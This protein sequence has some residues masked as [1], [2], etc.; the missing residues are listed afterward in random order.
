LVLTTSHVVGQQNEVYLTY[1]DQPAVRGR[2]VF[3]DT[4]ND[5][6]L[7]EIQ[8]LD[9]SLTPLP[10]GDS[11]NVNEGEDVILL[12]YPSGSF[13]ETRVRLARN[14]P[15]ELAIA[16]PAH[17]GNSGGPVLRA[18]DH[19]VVGLIGSTRELGSSKDNPKHWA[20]PISMVKKICRRQ[21]RPID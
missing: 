9:P 5:V 10:L 16:A 15:E 6:A 21:Q 14:T 1:R 3:A 2:V 20:V 8:D 11:D 13:F 19:T 4:A 12:G 7:V 17:P 18:S